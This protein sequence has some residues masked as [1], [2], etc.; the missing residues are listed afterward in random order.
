M[1]VS[2]EY[3]EIRHHR[4][5]FDRD[6]PPPACAYD[7]DFSVR[8]NSGGIV[9]E[10]L[11]SGSSGIKTDPLLIQ[12]ATARLALQEA[13]LRSNGNVLKLPD[14]DASGLSATVPGGENNTAGGSYSFAAGLKA[15][16]RTAAQV[17]GGD[18]H[19]DEGTFVWADATFAD[20]TSTGPN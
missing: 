19:G 16:V 3:I 6:A 18:P 4:G 17:G 14:P 8:E 5:Q 10:I 12:A 20:F 2:A 13:N 11:C 9:A 7:G 15:K 1:Y